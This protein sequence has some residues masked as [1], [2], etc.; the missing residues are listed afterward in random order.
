[1]TLHAPRPL[2]VKP[3]LT[4]EHSPTVEGIAVNVTADLIGR[5]WTAERAE[6]FAQRVLDNPALWITYSGNGA[7]RSDLPGG[8]A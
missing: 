5:G 3:R 8:A 4:E 6:A 1:M 7:R 2:Y